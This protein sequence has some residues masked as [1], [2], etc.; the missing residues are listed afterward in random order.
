MVNLGYS[1]GV[2]V[3]SIEIWEWAFC[4]NENIKIL[5]VSGSLY[6]MAWEGEENG[7]NSTGYPYNQGNRS[8]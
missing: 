5:W 6:W 3:I 2:S 7:K 4:E 8:I 1:P